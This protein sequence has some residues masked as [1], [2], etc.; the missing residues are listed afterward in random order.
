M[1]IIY[2]QINTNPNK[3]HEDEF[4]QNLKKL[5]TQGGLKNIYFAYSLLELI[6]L[7]QDHKGEPFWIISNF[8]P[9]SSYV[10]GALPKVNTQ[11]ECTYWEADGY[12]KSFNFFGYLLNSNN[13]PFL[14]IITGAPSSRL[15]IQDLCK[16]NPETQVKMKRKNQLVYEGDYHDNLLSYLSKQ[17]KLFKMD[18]LIESGYSHELDLP[19]K[20]ME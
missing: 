5:F 13:V 15:S 1:N 9:D 6:D 3:P 19:Q 11:T 12:E 14:S 16:I 18:V 4:R 7:M 10:D 20:E 17:I 8:P 2:G